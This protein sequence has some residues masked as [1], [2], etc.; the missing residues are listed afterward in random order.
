MAILT[1]VMFTVWALVR[2]FMNRPP[3][4]YETEVC[5]IRLKDKKYNEAIKNFNGGNFLSEEYDKIYDSFR[6]MLNN[7]LATENGIIKERMYILLKFFIYFLNENDLET[8][9]YLLD[10][11]FV[12]KINNTKVSIN[13]LKETM[14]VYDMYLTGIDITHDLNSVSGTITIDD[15]YKIIMNVNVGYKKLTI[16]SIE[17]TNATIA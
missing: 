11:D 3:G 13:H 9:K 8:V 12:I 7:F 16:R 1:F 5:D 15:T 17:I 14:E 6:N 2:S 10:D 4:D